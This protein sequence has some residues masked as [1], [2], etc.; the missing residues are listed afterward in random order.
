MVCPCRG[1]LSGAVGA[2]LGVKVFSSKKGTLPSGGVP[3]GLFRGSM[4]RLALWD[5]SSIPPMNHHTSSRSC[6][7]GHRSG[8]K[9]RRWPVF[10]EPIRRDYGLDG[11]R[12][13]GQGYEQNKKNEEDTAGSRSF[14]RYLLW[15]LDGFGAVK[16]LLVRLGAVLDQCF[17]RKE[18]QLF[19][20]TDL[21]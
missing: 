20:V 8:D 1:A 13:T 6:G 18:I 12:D 2:R 4:V 21:A 3:W 17:F 11:P 7:R 15:L 14:H 9:S 16:Q 19:N 5:P 10:G